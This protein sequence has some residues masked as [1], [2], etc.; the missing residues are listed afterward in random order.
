MFKIVNNYTPTYLNNILPTDQAKYILIIIFNADM[1]YQIRK[2]TILYS[3]YFLPSSVKMCNSVPEIFF[4]YSHLK[5]VK[6]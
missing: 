4:K 3:N 5:L 2:R 6:H 1:L